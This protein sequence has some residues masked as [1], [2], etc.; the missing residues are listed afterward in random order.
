MRRSCASTASDRRVRPKRS[1]GH[2]RARDARGALKSRLTHFVSSLS[3]AKIA[4]LDRALA[5]ALELPVP[6]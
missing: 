3:R 6:S 1:S 2:R 4:E 5:N